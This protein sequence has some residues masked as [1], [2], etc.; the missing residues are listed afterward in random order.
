MVS[1]GKRF[2]AYEI[3]KRLEEENKATI[4]LQLSKAVINS[5]KDKGKKHQYLSGHLIVGK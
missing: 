5:D 1:N 4:L 2:M 3:V